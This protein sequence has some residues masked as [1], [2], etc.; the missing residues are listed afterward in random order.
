MSNQGIIG[1]KIETEKATKRQI[2]LNKHKKARNS[3]NAPN[4]TKIFVSETFLSQSHK[5]VHKI[6]T[7]VRV[8]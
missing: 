7:I 5:I 6:L 2:K 3:Q 8:K 1:K 4:A